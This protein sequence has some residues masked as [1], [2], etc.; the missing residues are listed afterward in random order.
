M[1]AKKFLNRLLLILVGLRFRS[2]VR[3]AV[4]LRESPFRFLPM[5]ILPLAGVVFLLIAGCMDV[6]SPKVLPPEP[7]F[8]TDTVIRG[9]DLSM[10][11][12]IEEYGTV[13][14]NFDSIPER[15]TQ[16]LRKAGVNTVRLRLWKDPIDGENG[17][18]RVKQFSER[19]KRE[20]F[21]VMI[22][23]HYSDTWADPG[24]QKTPA[25]WQNLGFRELRDSMAQYT[26]KI[27]TAMKPEFIQIGNE[28]NNG[29]LYPTGGRYATP[30]RFMELLSV[31]AAAV[32]ESST[33]TKIIIHFAGLEGA[34]QFFTELKG[35]DYDII[36]LS[37]YPMWHGKD[38]NGIHFTINQL[39]LK[40][41][42]PVAI[43]ETSYPFT[44]AWH[45]WTNNILGGEEQLVEGYPATPE[46]QYNF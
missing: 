15:M 45:D 41:L 27:V 13:F 38:I 34:E 2:G 36:G 3:F 46:G 11:P 39:Y 7:P 42:K 21:R 31:A 10:L 25:I 23:V 1:F 37:Y 43:V 44:L 35:L 9:A 5:V 32:R 20:G 17:F 6:T 18:E 4:R 33:H 12:T 26:K 14:Y 24:A 40:F 19:L 29:F 16:T 8:V 28:I 22:S 30:N